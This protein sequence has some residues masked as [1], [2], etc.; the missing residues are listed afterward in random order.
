MFFVVVFSYLRLQYA[1]FGVPRGVFWRSFRRVRERIPPYR[2]SVSGSREGCF[3]RLFDGVECGFR[4]TDARLRVRVRGVLD[5]C[6]ICWTAESALQML[7]F[8]VARGVFGRLFDG[9][10]CGF[11]LTGAR[12][13]VRA[14]DGC[15]C[16]VGGL[17]DLLDCGIRL[18]DAR[19]RAPV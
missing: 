5:V 2:C 3:G 14:R 13:R 4:L 19:F 1:S 15:G 6:S 9:V 18:A 8:G 12:L 17:F 10:E 7:G 16:S 11:R